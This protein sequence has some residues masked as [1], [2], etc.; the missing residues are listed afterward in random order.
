MS[1]SKKTVRYQRGY[2]EPTVKGD[3]TKARGSVEVWVNSVDPVA[4]AG[5]GKRYLRLNCSGTYAKSSGIPYALGDI[6]N[7]NGTMFVRVTV[8]EPLC[9]Y[10]EKMS[11]GKGSRIQV[12]GTFNVSEFTKK[13]GSPGKNVECVAQKVEKKWPLTDGK[14]EQFGGYLNRLN[15]DEVGK[16]YGSLA[17]YLVKPVEIKKTSA[18]NEV[19]E[20]RLSGRFQNNSGIPYALGD[21]VLDPKDG[22]LFVSASAWSYALDS[23]KK[24]NLQKGALIQVYGHFEVRE[25]PRSDGTVGKDVVCR[26]IKKFEVLSFGKKEDGAAPAA[27]AAAAPAAPAAPAT[28]PAVDDDDNFQAPASFG[29]IVV[30]F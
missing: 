12:Y 20:V 2:I 6:L 9:D 8:F 15:V 26:D 28:A 14:G 16:A 27:P 11:L 5:N 23:F 13:D 30:P 25:Y 22:H 7:D 21:D 10:V 19:G 17:M 4:T 1:D 18:S 3:Q 24:L 29:D